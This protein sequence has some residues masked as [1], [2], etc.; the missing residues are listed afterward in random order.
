M[1]L[2]VCTSPDISLPDVNQFSTW[3]DLLKAT[4]T[5]LH[6]AAASTT[7]S[8]DN[9]ESHISA[10]KLLLQRA[11]KDSFPEEFKALTSGRPL[12]S[13]S[14]LASLSPEYDRISGLIR[15][16]GR[17]RHAKHIDLD[18]MHPIVLDPQHNLTKLLIKDCD[19]S[20]LHPG[21]ERVFAEL[22]RRYWILRGSEAIK[23]HQYWCMEC[24][25]WRAKP[26][27]PKMADLPPT[28]LRL[29]RPPFYST[30]MDC[31]GPFRVKIGRRTE[32]RWGIVFKCLTTRCLHLDVLESL[33][34]DA[35]LTLS[36]MV[37]T[38]VDS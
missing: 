22:R 26:S 19:S 18:A 35:F 9:S 30:G 12:P 25:K 5:S 20:L 27:I 17:L 14:R 32:K 11:Q 15:V 10:E 24:Q 34:T 3:T 31:F 37:S 7:Q 16:G 6:G 29:Y 2:Q 28:R 33:D 38:F 8:T 4:V 1:C 23:K 21:P 36:C 13:N